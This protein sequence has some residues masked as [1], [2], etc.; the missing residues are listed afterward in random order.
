MLVNAIAR[1]RKKIYEKGLKKG[2]QEGLKEGEM[3]EK[4]QI[5]RTMLAG[6][7]AISDIAAIT[8]LWEEDIRKIT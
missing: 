4:R 5:A 6:D 7:M 2:K 1:D 8:G 3:K